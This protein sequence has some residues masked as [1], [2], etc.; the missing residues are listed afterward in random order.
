LL[1]ASLGQLDI[2]G[3]LSDALERWT[4]DDAFPPGGTGRNAA[5]AVVRDAC[6]AAREGVRH[7]FN[8][9]PDA[10]VEVTPLSEDDES[11]QHSYYVPPRAG[12]AEPGVLW[13]NLATT[14]AQPRAEATVLAFHEAWPG[15]HLQLSIAQQARLSPL[16]RALLFNAYLEGWAKYAESLPEAL[17][18]VDDISTRIA[19]LRTELYSTATLV[20]DTGVHVHGWTADR[21]REFFVEQTGA[22]RSLADMVVLRSAANPA[23]LCAYKIGL[24]KLRK[25]QRDYAQARGTAYNTRGFH[26]AYLGG[27]ALPLDVLERSMRTR[28]AQENRE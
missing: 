6:V 2:G 11:G 22:S 15:H 27:G 4:R 20:L 12:G 3:N 10:D 28:A 16:R 19:R 23:Q 17:G 24:M 14:A 5:L 9:W 13:L 21:A 7:A 25:L 1:A 26:D 8:L 18:V